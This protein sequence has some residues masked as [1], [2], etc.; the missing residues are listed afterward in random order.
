M[1]REILFRGKRIDNGEW[2][3]GFYVNCS[4]PGCQ[5]YESRHYIIEYPDKWHEVFTS[6]VHQYTGVKDKHGSR[7]FEGDIIK[8]DL[9]RPYLVVVFRGGAFEH[10]CDDG[11]GIYYDIMFA[12]SEEE[13]FVDKYSKV[14]GNVCDNPEYMED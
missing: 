1:S 4:G 12:T 13:Q 10:E 3:Y 7:I 6:T 5:R 8:T 11:D 9:A 14:I 2:V